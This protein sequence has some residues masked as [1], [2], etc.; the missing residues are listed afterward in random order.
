MAKKDQGGS[1][2]GGG[3]EF[4]SKK[5]ERPS[6][7]PYTQRP[8]NSNLGMST[9]YKILLMPLILLV[10]ALVAFVTIKSPQHDFFSFFKKGINQAPP[11]EI[12]M[13]MKQSAESNQPISQN[14]M[15]RQEQP[16]QNTKATSQHDTVDTISD[17]L[18]EEEL[19]RWIAS[20][21][22]KEFHFLAKHLVENGYNKP[23][24]ILK[25]LIDE[26]SLQ[27]RDI[28]RLVVLYEGLTDTSGIKSVDSLI[29]AS[30]N[31]N[32]KIEIVIDEIE[33]PELQPTEQNQQSGYV[34]IL[35]PLNQSKT[36]NS[37]NSGAMNSRKSGRVT[38]LQPLVSSETQ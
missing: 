12:I 2:G 35:K 38:I 13:K 21:I 17:Y 16:L 14:S 37:D 6:T 23:K 7:K 33:D 4:T 36:V 31:E 8:P 34:T 22:P 15:G 18:S 9:A 25:V 10:V 32:E 20:N 29:Y 11:P 5:E 30:Q 24:E 26:G 27:G 19:A 1:Y 28:A 3:I